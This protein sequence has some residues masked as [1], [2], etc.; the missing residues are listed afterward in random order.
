[1]GQSLNQM[2]R[3]LEVVTDPFLTRLQAL[4][5]GR[6]NIFVFKSARTDHDS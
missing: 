6:G 5:I 4:E 1:M 3:V 2:V